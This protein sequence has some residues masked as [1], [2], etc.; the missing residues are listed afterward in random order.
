MA[1]VAVVGLLRDKRTELARIVVQMEH[2]L[3]QRRAD[4]MRLDATMQLF[5]PDLRPGEVHSR[6]ERTRSIWFGRDKCLRLIYDELREAPEPLTR[7][8]LAERIMRVKAMAVADERQ[9]ALIQKTILGGLPRQGGHDRHAGEL[10]C[11]SP[12]RACLVCQLS[13]AG[14]AQAQTQVSGSIH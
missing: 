1:K 7:R 11:Q 14:L 8:D 5:D 6:Q 3:V 10:G 12:H 4:L 2:Q 9:R 13:A